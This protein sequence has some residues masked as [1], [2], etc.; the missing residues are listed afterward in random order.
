MNTQQLTQ[1]PMTSIPGQP[2]GYAP[3][4]GATPPVSP[5][6]TPTPQPTQGNA[7][8]RRWIDGVITGGLVCGAIFSL[9]TWA[10]VDGL[11]SGQDIRA[12][13]RNATNAN[14]T[15]VAVEQRALNAE[16]NAQQWQQHAA[17]QQQTLAQVQELICR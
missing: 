4:Y 2:I 13:E 12:L 6:M 5:A 1:A 8:Q 15:A 17:Q 16:A 11:Y 14:A 3:V 7:G 10:V 9:V